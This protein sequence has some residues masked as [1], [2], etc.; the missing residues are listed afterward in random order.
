MRKKSLLL[1]M[2]LMLVVLSAAGCGPKKPAS[3]S[4][5]AVFAEVKD[6]NGRT[7]K[8]TKKP[9]RIVVASASFLEPLHE[10]GGKIVAR[11]ESKTINPDFAK[12]IPSI[13]RVYNIDV[14]KLL[15]YNPDL[16]VLNKAT[17]E[18]LIQPLETAGIPVIVAHL[19]SY[20]DVKDGIRLFASVTGEK[21]KGEKLIV[22]M[23]NK[24]EAIKGKIPKKELRVLILHGTS[25]GLSVQLE[26]SIGGSV[27]KMLGFTNVAAGMKAMDDRPDAAPY[28][29]ETVV[30]QNPDVIFITSMGKIDDI[31]ASMEQTMKSNPAWQS[32]PAV[33]DNKIYYLSQELFLLSPCIHYPEAVEEMAKLIYPEA[34]K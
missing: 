25:Q 15:A 12:D 22:D 3:S 13:G 8:L 18:K 2:I 5:D 4:S 32:I 23:D 29:I 26:S 1:F 33:R 17:N 10:V 7:V 24:I 14:E 19:K 20:D 30:E 27:A 34:F 9:E 31:K 28:S 6:A 21:E 16:V 11:P